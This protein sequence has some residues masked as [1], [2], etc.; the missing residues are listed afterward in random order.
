M[1]T[2]VE[3]TVAAQMAEK[4]MDIIKWLEVSIKQSTDFVA[5]QMP[6]F[7]QE[8][9]NYNFWY[10]LIWFLISLACFG[11]VTFFIWLITRKNFYDIGEDE[12]EDD[13][14]YSRKV[15]TSSA[16]VKRVVVTIIALISFI[17]GMCTVQMDFIKIKIAPRLYL[18]DY[19]TEKLTTK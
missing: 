6:L 5:E 11:F 8:L 10:S 14:Y 12:M 1:E 4:S 19:A 18:L 17:F 9:L 13:N 3:Q 2:K 7:I 15:P 16:I